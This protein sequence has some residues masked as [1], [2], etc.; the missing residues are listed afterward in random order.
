MRALDYL[1]YDYLAKGPI[2][3]IRIGRGSSGRRAAEQQWGAET[4]LSKHKSKT[5]N[6]HIRKCQ[7]LKEIKH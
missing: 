2:S 7:C 5:Q 1:R 3:K 4:K 6:K